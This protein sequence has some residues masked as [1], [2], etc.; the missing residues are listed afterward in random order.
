MRCL[1]KR[2][3][4]SLGYRDSAAGARNGFSYWPRSHEIG[5]KANRC[6]IFC[7]AASLFAGEEQPFYPAK[8]AIQLPGLT[9]T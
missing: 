7:S 8:Q 6:P 5:G 2:A 1:G 3:C 9:P 4:G